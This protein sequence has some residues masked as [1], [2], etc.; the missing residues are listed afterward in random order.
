MRLVSIRGDGEPVAGML[1]GE[2]V[3]PLAE[4][5]PS[6]PP[7]L[8]EIVRSWPSYR[9]RLLDV[10][11]DPGAVRPVEEVEL[12]IPFEPVRVLA[13]GG[14]YSAHAAEMRS[15]AAAAEPSG[16][17]KLPGTAQ[18]PNL[19]L[20]LRA[21]DR[22]VD[23]EGEIAMVVGA[24]ARDLEASEAADYIAGLMLANDVSARNSPLAQITLAKAAPGFCPL[25]PWLVTVDEL[26]LDAI[27]FAVEVNGE[28]RQST[29]T[30]TMIH[31]FTEILASYSRSVPLE[32]GDVIL[33][34]TPGGVG[35]GQQPPIFLAPG[36]E[37]VV[38]SPQ[39]G[40]LRTPVVAAE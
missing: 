20:Q 6:L 16:F 9:E 35:I 13:T 5:D 2:R 38:S 29:T 11:P 24:P 10:E 8:T 25:G 32:P 37:I 3:I 23:Y 21:E 7:S 22:F 1:V 30:A 40:A 26:D 27:E 17:L 4:L 33:T 28:P 19:P 39:L 14:N 18:G 31:S 34:G 36:D 15:T 12:A